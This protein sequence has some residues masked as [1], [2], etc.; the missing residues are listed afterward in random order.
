MRSTSINYSRMVE[1]LS[2]YNKVLSAPSALGSWNPETVAGLGSLSREVGRQATM[3]AYL[4]A[5]GLFTIACALTIPLILSP[6]PPR[7]DR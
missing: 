6:P 1:Q 3:L 5:F 2:P 4:N 7:P